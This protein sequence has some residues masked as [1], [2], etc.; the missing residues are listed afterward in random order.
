MVIM[1]GKAL[2]EKM[3][4]QLK[5]RVERLKAEQG[6]VPGL[7]VILVGDDP[8]SQVY[9]RNKAKACESVGMN[10]WVHRLPK[11]TS[12]EELKALIQKVNEDNQVHGLLVQLP[13]PVGL[14]PDRV[15]SWIQPEKDPDAL[16]VE[17]VGLMWSGRPR[18]A[19]CTPSGV[20]ELLKEYDVEVEGRRAVVV[21]RSQ[22]VGQP[23]ALLLQNANATVTV[24]HSK[25]PDIK[26]HT[27]EADIVVVAAGR[28]RFMGKEHFKKGAVVVD[29]GIHRLEQPINGKSLCG[30]VRFEEL[31]GWASAATPVPRGVGPMTIAML[32]EN[33]YRLA[34]LS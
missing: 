6:K 4:G 12:A 16:T 20:M 26:T 8:A 18:V 3:R 21:G 15:L 11:E 2:S 34:S 31:D 27:C 10:S 1:D 33:T 13:L 17:N 23:M 28:P 5:E 29:V 30:D 24:V 19:P 25:T 7:T 22:I 9:V 14:D 32:L